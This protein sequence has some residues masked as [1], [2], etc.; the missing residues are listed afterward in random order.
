MR[1]EGSITRHLSVHLVL[2]V[3]GWRAAA[4][5]AVS[6]H[7]VTVR[8]LCWG[9]AWVHSAGAHGHVLGGRLQTHN[10]E[11]QNP[12]NDRNEKDSSH[13]SRSRRIRQAQ[14]RGSGAIGN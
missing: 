12:I 3:R 4:D 5:H 9:P 13:P 7:A 1:R 14:E 2:H 11:T 10:R 8:G 6:G